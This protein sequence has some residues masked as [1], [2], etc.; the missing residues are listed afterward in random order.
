MLAVTLYICVKVVPPDMCE[1]VSVHMCGC[2]S[3]LS[4]SGEEYYRVLQ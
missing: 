4:S 3:Y 2:V 1:T